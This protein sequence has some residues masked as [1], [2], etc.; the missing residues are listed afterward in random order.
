MPALPLLATV[1]G[2]GVRTFSRHFRETLGRALHA[3]V[4]DRR[5]AR[6]KRLLSH[7]DLAIKESSLRLRLCR[8]GSPDPRFSLSAGQHACPATPR[9]SGLSFRRTRAARCGIERSSCSTNCPVRSRL[10]SPMVP[11]FP[12]LRGAD[13]AGVSLDYASPFRQALSAPL[14]LG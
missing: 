7:G 14:P 5:V 12:E 8:S 13:F 2:M 9:V 11:Y 1:A 4:I 3:F 6:A 10:P